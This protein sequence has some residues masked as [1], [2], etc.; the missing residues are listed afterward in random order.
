MLI[1]LGLGWSVHH[2][3]KKDRS[4]SYQ[5]PETATHD[6]LIMEHYLHVVLIMISAV[7][8]ASEIDAEVL[9]SCRVQ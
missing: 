6:H 1:N 2:P 7:S 3:K 9:E 4:V 5:M 8:G